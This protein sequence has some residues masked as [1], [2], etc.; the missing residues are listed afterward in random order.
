MPLV[1]L[2]AAVRPQ[3]QVVLVVLLE[4]VEMVVT[5]KLTMQ[6]LGM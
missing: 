4:S 6:P 1:V 2:V 3:Q 5:I